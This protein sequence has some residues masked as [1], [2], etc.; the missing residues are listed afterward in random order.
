MIIQSADES[1]DLDYDELATLQQL[2]LNGGLKRELK[3]SSS[4]LGDQLDI[5]TQT[6][7]RRLQNL[8]DAGLIYRQSV[9][10]G[11]YVFIRKEGEQIL[12][13]EYEQY[14][15]IFESPQDIELT[16]TVVE[17]MGKGKHFVSLSG[18]S[19]QFEEKFGYTP[20]P[21][22]LNVELS[23]ASARTWSRLRE[24]DPIRIE[25]W[26]DGET[27]YGPV[28]SYPGKIEANEQVYK[29]VHVIVPERTEHEE[30]NLEVV[31]PEELR[32]RLDIESGS[33]V[34]I[35]VDRD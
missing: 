3:I 20:F 8:W 17:G 5:S 13:N 30:D 26:S 19:E 4:E 7:N 35:Y 28:Y 14:R 15:E 2:A 23:P 11:Q 27:T 22:T 12:W 32:E 9:T 18:Y 16:G 24:I 31:A 6:A 10:D 33:Q 29:P 1:V 34:I 21:G 25:G